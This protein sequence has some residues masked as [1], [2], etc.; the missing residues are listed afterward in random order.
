MIKDLHSG[1]K[2]LYLF[3]TMTSVDT[4]ACIESF[5]GDRKIS[6]MYGDRHGSIKKACKKIGI[7]MDESSWIAEEQLDD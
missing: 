7:R 1:L 4:Q 2:A 5:K 3:A 6:C